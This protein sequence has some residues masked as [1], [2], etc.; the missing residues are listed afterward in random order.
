MVLLNIYFKNGTAEQVA[1]WCFTVSSFGDLIINFD[2]YRS[3]TIPAEEI[4]FLGGWS[5]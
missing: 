1:A 5:K 3:R 2:E 4:D